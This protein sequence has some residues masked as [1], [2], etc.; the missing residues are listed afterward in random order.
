MFK[1]KIKPITS[2]GNDGEESL[3]HEATRIVSILRI[4]VLAVLIV[5]M[6]LV[7]TGVYVY[8]RNYED[9][10]FQKHF[11]DGAYQVIANFHEFIEHNIGAAAAMSTSITSYAKGQNDT[12]FPFVTVPDF[13]LLGS[14]LRELSGSHI[15][16]WLPLVRDEDRE[17]WESYAYDN[18][19]HIDKA[20]END[21][22]FRSKQDTELGRV[23]PNN[24]SRRLQDSTPPSNMTMAADE[25]GYHMKIWSN[26]ATTNKGDMP[27]GSGP[28]L[29]AWQRR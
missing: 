3:A 28:Y 8:T 21:V 12:N 18:R 16:H 9:D 25:S 27:E 1:Q 20:Y 7:S 13:E 26:G 24:S 29:P 23:I 14:H 11:E 22:Y 10:T 6:A 19:H 4:V 2:Q 5:T 15:V 17:A